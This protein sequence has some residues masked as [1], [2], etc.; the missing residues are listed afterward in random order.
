MGENVKFVVILM[1]LASGLFASQEKAINFQGVLFDAS[2]NIVPDS[3]YTLEFGIYDAEIAGTKIWSEIQLTSTSNGVYQVTLGAVSSLNS[4]GFDKPYF[5]QIIVNSTVLP[6]RTKL[7][8]VPFAI[9][10]N[11]A[12]SA[13][14][15]QTAGSALSAG[16]ASKSV[17][18][19]TATYASSAASAATAGTAA[20]A[21]SAVTALK[22]DTAQYAYIALRTASGVSD[23]AKVAQ[24]L[25]PGLA[26]NS[27]N[28]LTD[29]ITLVAS[30]GTLNI[31]QTGNQIEIGSELFSHGV[32]VKGPCD[33]TARS[34]FHG[35]LIW[36]F[37]IDPDNNDLY[38]LTN[39]DF[40]L[41]G[42]VVNSKER[43][44]AWDA[45]SVLSLKNDSTIQIHNAKIIVNELAIVESAS[46]I[47]A[48]LDASEMLVKK[49]IVDSASQIHATLDASE[50]SV[51]KA[52][53]DSASQ[54]HASLDASEILVKKAIKDT[55]A[56]IRV[57]MTELELALDTKVSSPW[58]KEEGGKL[59][60][61]TLSNSVDSLFGIHLIG[62]S[63]DGVGRR[64]S[65]WNDPNYYDTVGTFHISQYT[66]NDNDGDFCEAAEGEIC[67]TRFSILANGFV[68]ID[69]VLPRAYLDVPNMIVGRGNWAGISFDGHAAGHPEVGT[70]WMLN[71]HNGHND[72]LIREYSSDLNDSIYS[73]FPTRLQIHSG[74]N[75]SI[76]NTNNSY[77][78]DVTGDVNFTGE[79]TVGK[80]VNDPDISIDLTG[81]DFEP[82]GGTYQGPK[83]YKDKSNRIHLSGLVRAIANFASETGVLICKL[84][85]GYEPEETLIFVVSA[86]YR[87]NSSSSAQALPVH[88]YVKE[89]GYVEFSVPNGYNFLENI[90]WV[91]LSGI[92]FRA[93]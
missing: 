76:G 54:I 78:L 31:T 20:T 48:S 53:V 17:Y 45:A 22:S 79:V 40:V 32:K 64:W 35:I 25:I 27:I 23:T 61:V 30:D 18:A 59:P 89:T 12:D 41:L 19:D 43:N 66:D 24:G 83:I 50:M 51:K 3:T 46:Q 68:G 60:G 14:H 33:S 49:A 81:Y 91:S 26:V 44:D 15:A 87:A 28:G 5:V 80:L 74:G 10:S 38:L 55:A 72:F 39:L 77:K 34:G 2:G 21:A 56:Q 57:S 4:L 47:H 85:V 88:L 93:Q 71:A 52:I 1:V 86:G 65:I 8:T 36:D 82:Y 92:S 69:T 29:I 62:K 13:L 63:K 90:D 75:I 67:K 84:P 37:C 42:Q 11:K 6:M 70:D 9:Q 7:T 73:Y 16:V 58:V